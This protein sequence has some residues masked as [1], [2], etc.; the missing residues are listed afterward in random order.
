MKLSKREKMLL[1]VL[2]VLL[3]LGA[4]YKFI[5]ISQKAKIDGLKKDKAVYVEKVDKLNTLVA[6]IPQKESDI[7]V[8]TT[9]IKDKGIKLYPDII[10][11]NIIRELDK[12]IRDSGINGSISF[13]EVAVSSIETSKKEE[14]KLKDSKLEDL[15]NQYNNLNTESTVKKNDSENN[16]TTKTEDKGQFSNGETKGDNK[17]AVAKDENSSKVQQLKVTLNFTGA[18]NNIVDFVKRLEDY[19]KHI[20]MVSIN[21]SQS[22]ET[23]ITGTCVLEFFAI[24]KITDEDKN[25]FSWDLRNPYGKENIFDGSMSINP[26]KTVEDITNTGKPKFDFVMSVK[27]Q[28]SDI[29]TI[30]L[31]RANDTDRQSYVYA[32]SNKVENIEIVLEKEKDKYYFRYKTSRD[33]YPLN[34]NDEKIEFNPGLSDVYFNILSSL[35]LTADDKSGANIKLTNKTDKKIVVIIE[36]EDA[37]SPRIKIEGEGGNIEVKQAP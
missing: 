6:T 9:K 17:S 8:I 32:D 5:F 18:Y 2:G 11:E 15:K 10:Q 36:G 30:I 4:Y 12:L 16:S 14:S 1:A 25:Y 33:S 28:S 23:E 19:S 20:A 24:P 3:F 37:T 34:F 29:P 22:S 35:R 26:L 13:S 21:I 27:P 31:G 7:K